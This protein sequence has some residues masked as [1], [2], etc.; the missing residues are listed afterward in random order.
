MRILFV[1]AVMAALPLLAQETTDAQASDESAPHEEAADTSD[2]EG[3]VDSEAGQATRV[4]IYRT[5]AKARGEALAKSQP[6]IWLDDA[7]TLWMARLDALRE[8]KGVALVVAAGS[9]NGA[10]HLARWRSHLPALGFQTWY[11]IATEPLDGE[12]LNSARE[13]IN[14]EDITL[15]TDATHCGRMAE[16][17]ADQA[18]WSGLTCVNPD[19]TGALLEA[20]PLFSTLPI[21]VLVLMEQPLAW[22]A[23][24]PKAGNVEVQQL[25][26]S[27]PQAADALLLRRFVGWTRRLGAGR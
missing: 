20:E 14:A 8:R 21:P 11:M 2:A 22:P 12:L 3:S 17:I 23:L 15:V 25:P 1:L 6:V 4:R 5:A 27:A 16:L 18:Q 19:L 7:Q 9:P 13:R 24:L 26:V 10:G